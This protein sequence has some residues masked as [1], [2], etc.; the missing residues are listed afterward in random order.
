M[1]TF[2]GVT[3]TLTIQG[4]QYG[5]NATINVES[6]PEGNL[7]VVDIGGDGEERLSGTCVFNSFANLRT[8][9]GLAA[10]GTTGTL[11]YAEQ[12][13]PAILVS[14]QRNQVLPGKHIAR[15]EW[16]LTG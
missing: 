4:H 10:H 12:T 1:A 5:A 7:I 16:I 8:M 9:I 15:C 14:C 6:I 2:S 11:V 3:F 13:R